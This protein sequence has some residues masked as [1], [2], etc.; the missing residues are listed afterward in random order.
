MLELIIKGGIMMVP[1]MVE[2]VLAL[3]VLFDRWKAF[4]ENERIDVRALRAKVTRL[5]REDKV[6]EA[7]RLCASTSGPVAAVLLAGLQAYSKHRALASSPEA[8]RSLVEDALEDYAYIANKAV[9]KRL[10]VLSFIGN[11][12]PLFGMTGTVTGMIKSFN[13]MA[14]AGALEGSVV[15]G[16]ISEALITTAAGLLIAMAAVIPYH[17]FM[18]RAEAVETHIHEAGMELLDFVTL[19]HSRT[20]AS[21]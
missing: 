7:C 3:A 17:Y 20:P 21:A 9:E 10:N 8:L 11:S 19:R 16:G 15:A 2:S 14:G 1:L 18:G 12:A 6:E 13:A 5:L 4:R